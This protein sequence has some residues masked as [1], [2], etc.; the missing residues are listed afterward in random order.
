VVDAIQ[1]FE[2]QTFDPYSI[3][4]QVGRFDVGPFSAAMRAFVLAGWDG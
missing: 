2:A 1:A 3:R 4:E